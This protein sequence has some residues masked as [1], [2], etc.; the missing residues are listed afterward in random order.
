MYRLSTKCMKDLRLIEETYTDR[1]RLGRMEKDVNTET[2]LQSVGKFD[3]IRI[4]DS[5]SIDKL[6]ATGRRDFQHLTVPMAS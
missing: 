1:K 6:A 5:Y 3:I 4:K 2:T